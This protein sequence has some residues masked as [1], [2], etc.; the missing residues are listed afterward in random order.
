[1]ARAL[2]TPTRRTPS[3]TRGVTYKPDS[4]ILPGSRGI[5]R[6]RRI[7]TDPYELRLSAARREDVERVTGAEGF[8][9]QR[10]DI[11]VAFLDD[12]GAV[13]GTI[14]EYSG[15]VDSWGI[16][17][18]GDRSELLITLESPW[19]RFELDNARY[20]SDNS[21]RDLYPSDAFFGGL[22]GEFPDEEWG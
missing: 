14:K 1:M 20:A 18:N 3:P 9:G 22:K 19:S 8:R 7:N 4:G 13:V 12:A 5:K 2:R 17:L 11:L 16:V 6:T 21:Q 10:V 15:Y